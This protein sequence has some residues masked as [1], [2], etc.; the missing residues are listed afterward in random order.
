M[1]GLE[2]LSLVHEKSE[3]EVVS[4]VIATTETAMKLEMPGKMEY[5]L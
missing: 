5:M 1:T 2:S 3:P 4:E